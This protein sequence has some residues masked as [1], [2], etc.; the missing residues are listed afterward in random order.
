[1]DGPYRVVTQTRQTDIDNHRS[2]VES[3]PSAGYF[4][5]CTAELTYLVEL[6]DFVK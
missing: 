4:L 5:P 1:M 3:D 2:H 6:V